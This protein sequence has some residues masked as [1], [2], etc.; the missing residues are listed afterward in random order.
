MPLQVG[1]ATRK[2]VKMTVSELTL[3]VAET[4]WTSVHTGLMVRKS[5]NAYRVL[6]HMKSATAYFSLCT[7]NALG[8]KIKT[9][10]VW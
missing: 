4:W 10:S 1:A 5:C 8:N 3:Y 2:V 6:A 9:S 7:L